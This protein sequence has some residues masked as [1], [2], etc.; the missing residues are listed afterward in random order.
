M[1]KSDL[2]QLRS[3]TLDKLKAR[4]LKEKKELANLYFEVR[5][6]KIKDTRKIFH[7]RKDIGRI[8]TII[9]EKGDK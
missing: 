2:Q 6:K 5:T 7:K 8:L 9:A 3:E 1:K 4:L